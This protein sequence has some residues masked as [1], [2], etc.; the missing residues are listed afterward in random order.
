MSP[1]RSDGPRPTRIEPP[2]TEAS[3]PFWDATRERRLVLPWCLA[4]ERAFWFPREVCPRCLSSRIEWRQASG[5]GEV[6][7]FTV[8]HRPTQLQAVFGDAPYVIALVELDEGV[9]LM[10]NVVGVATGGAAVGLTVTVT[11]EPMSDGRHLVL[12][13]PTEDRED[14]PG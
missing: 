9:R 7:A 6:Y 12:F 11:W 4:C 5:R 13:T 10:S 2:V 8:E 14:E 3:A 1:T